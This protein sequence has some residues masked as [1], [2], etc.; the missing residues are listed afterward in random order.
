MCM[1]APPHMICRPEEPSPEKSRF[2]KLAFRSC[3]TLPAD[4]T[5]KTHDFGGTCRGVRRILRCKHLAS[6]RDVFGVASLGGTMR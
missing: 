2:R 5:T 3:P 4:N 1:A 6:L